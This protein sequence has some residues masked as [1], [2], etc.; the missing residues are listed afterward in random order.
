MGSEVEDSG[1]FNLGIYIKTSHNL[2]YQFAAVLS[3]EELHPGLGYLFK[4]SIHDSLIL[5]AELEL[6]CFNG[7]DHHLYCSLRSAGLN[8]INH[9]EAFNLQPPSQQ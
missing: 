2:R 9:D 3:G 5:I 1:C 6:S 7:L 4:F 8:I